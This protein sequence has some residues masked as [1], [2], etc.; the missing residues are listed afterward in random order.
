MD[1]VISTQT[2]A[3]STDK[4]PVELPALPS[5]YHLLR[6]LCE[7]GTSTLYLA[8]DLFLYSSLVVV[9]C[10]RSEYLGAV[11]ARALAKRE[12]SIARQLSHPNL[13]KIYDCGQYQGAEYLIM[14]YLDGSS[15]A[16]YLGRNEFNYTQALTIITPLVYVL[17]YLHAQGLVHADIKPGNIIITKD[18]QVKLIDLANCRQDSTHNSPSVVLGDDGFFGYSRD[19]SSPQVIS[20]QPAAPSDD[21]FSLASVIYEL[22]EACPAV[23]T[24]EQ[25]VRQVFNI[26]A[27]P[28]A[29]NYWQWRVLRRA[30]AV[31]RSKRYQ[32]VDKFFTHFLAARYLWQKI[33]GFFLVLCLLSAAIFVVWHY[34]YER[35]SRVKQ[36]QA[37]YQQQQALEADIS[38]VK[39]KPATERH[40]WL[41]HFDHYPEWLRQGALAALYDDVV[42]PLVEHINDAV[43]SQYAFEGFEL[44]NQSIHNALLFY[45]HSQDLIALKKLLANEQVMIVDSIAVQLSHMIDDG[46]YT[47]NKAQEI[48]HLVERLVKFDALLKHQNIIDYGYINKQYRDDYAVY[49]NKIV[50]END[51]FAFNTAYK[52]SVILKKYLPEF[53]RVWNSFDKSLVENMKI[54]SDYLGSESGDVISYPYSAAEFFLKEKFLISQA[55]IKNL[56]FNKDIAFHVDSLLSLR[57]KYKIP[58]DF[59]W[60]QQTKNILNNKIIEKI[61]FHNKNNQK[62]S[63]K[64]LQRLSARLA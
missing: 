54:M 24:G 9:K 57:D 63:V 28:S 10:L 40:R 49:I 38:L 59:Y 17:N 35:Y 33:I 64:K 12:A 41:S 48:N 7:G 5:R 3:G 52:F 58:E 6:P 55:A 29:I 43:L 21:V 44:F 32:S 45:P 15:L 46:V 27:K 14:E 2:I 13:I 61:K 26:T 36:Q 22:L 20:D 47:P 25:A 37:V 31:D 4:Q 60:Y 8:R 16:E 30:T 34:S 1:A 50:D 62:I 53:Y 23:V 19:Y 18:G 51:F 39:S 56:W 42:L 11:P